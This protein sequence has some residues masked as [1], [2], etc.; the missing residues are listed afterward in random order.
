MR[1]GK[2]SEGDAE[3]AGSISESGLECE[4]SVRPGVFNLDLT[5]RA[6]FALK[7]R[8]GKMRGINDDI[9]RE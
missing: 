5:R 7:K 8:R 2:V 3:R 4:A 9:E 1:T 6:V